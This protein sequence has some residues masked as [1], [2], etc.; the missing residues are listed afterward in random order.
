MIQGLK[1]VVTKYAGASV[2]KLIPTQKL[3]SFV[4]GLTASVT[5]NKLLNILVNNIDIV[6]SVGGLVAGILDY[7]T[8]KKLDNRIW[9]FTW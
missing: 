8:D 9:V 2:A 6:L 1:K 5:I 7:A 3:T 4:A